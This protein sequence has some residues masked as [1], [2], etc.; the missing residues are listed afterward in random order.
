MKLNK[1]LTRRE[2]LGLT[3]AQAAGIAVGVALAGGIG[4]Y[5]LGLKSG[6][7]REKTITQTVT[8]EKLLPQQ[9]LQNLPTTV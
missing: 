8:Q 6:A 7:E 9:L 2:F 1:K 4:G 5:L 3:T